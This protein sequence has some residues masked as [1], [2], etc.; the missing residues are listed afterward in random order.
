MAL[1]GS[2]LRRNVRDYAQTHPEFLLRVEGTW[3]RSNRRRR[4]AD[5]ILKVLGDVIQA[6]SGIDDSRYEWT[7]HRR[8]DK[9]E[10]LEVAIY[11]ISEE[12]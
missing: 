4:D 11:A 7:T 1:L 9:P 6:V 3:V 10:G 8:Y 2:P 12:P 5:N